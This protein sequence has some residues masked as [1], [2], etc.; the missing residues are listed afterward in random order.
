MIATSDVEDT[1]ISTIS[2]AS[3]NAS[4]TAAVAQTQQGEKTKTQST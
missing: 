3:D 4:D 1:A 2:S